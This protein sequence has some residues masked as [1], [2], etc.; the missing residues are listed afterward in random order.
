[1]KLFI[2]PLG[3]RLRLT[4]EWQTELWHE[5]RNRALLDSLG[6]PHMSTYSEP[7][8]ASVIALPPMTVL[9]VRRI[10]I[11]EGVSEYDSVTFSLPRM[12]N[13]HIQWQKPSNQQ[14]R[15]WVKLHDA[16]KI[17]CEYLGQT[18]KKEKK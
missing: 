15:F 16:N 13:M 2:P 18:P 11:R 3:A 5:Y 14:L 10:Y 8:A 4:A 7:K 6:I 12:D 1:M 17:E 9:V